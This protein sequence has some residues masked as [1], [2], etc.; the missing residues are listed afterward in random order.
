MTDLSGMR[1]VVV[2]ASGAYGPDSRLQSS[3][4]QPTLTDVSRG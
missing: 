2:I 1:D 3:L 4:R